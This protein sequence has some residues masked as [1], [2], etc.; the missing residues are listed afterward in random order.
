MNVKDKN[1]DTKEAPAKEEE[2]IRLIDYITPDY[3]Q[4]YVRRGYRSRK[5][6]KPIYKKV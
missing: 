1:K 6:I 2:R 3:K 5:V 4:K